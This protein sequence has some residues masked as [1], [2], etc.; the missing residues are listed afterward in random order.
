VDRS[1]VKP[2]PAPHDWQTLPV[3]T[4]PPI[5]IPGVSGIQES[6]VRRAIVRAL[7]YLIEILASLRDWVMKEPLLEI[8]DEDTGEPDA[9]QQHH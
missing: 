4:R 9:K 2:E 7:N 6:I 3:D 1:K 5:D 8:Q